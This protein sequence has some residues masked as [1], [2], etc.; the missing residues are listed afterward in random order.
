MQA[1]FI[2]EELVTRIRQ[3]TDIVEVVSRYV[4]L[5]KAGKNLSGLCPFHAEKSPSFLVNPAKQV[6]HCFGC[7]AGGNV[8][9]FL[10]RLEGQ[11]FPQV[12]RSLAER[13]GIA[14]PERP[15]DAA[16]TQEQRER[17]GLLE[18]QRQAA[19]YFA[20]Q[21]HTSPAAAPARQ[22]LQE[23]GINAATIAAFRL[24]FAPAAWDGL[25]TE[26]RRKGWSEALIDRGGLAIPRSG[27]A[28]GRSGYYDRFRNRVMFPICDVQDRI[29]GF[30]GRVLD[31]STPK[32]LNS[33]ETPLFSKGRNLYAL[34]RARSGAG[35]RNYIVVV[36]G[37]FD[38]IMAHQVGIPVVVATLGTALTPNHLQIMQRFSGTVK[39]IFDPDPA[40]IRAALRAVDMI[41]PSGMSAEVV[42]LP[43]G[44]DP[45]TF[46]RKQGPQAFEEQ[47]AR[48]TNLLDFA[49]EQHLL[50]P[51]A[52]TLAG[53]LKIAQ[54]LIGAIQRIAHPLAR[55]YQIKRLAEGIGFKEDDLLRELDRRPRPEARPAAGPAP[56]LRAPLPREE[57][58]LAHLVIH[59]LVPLAQILEQVEI[60][61][62]TD[63]R[64]QLVVQALA[65]CV[66]TRGTLDLESLADPE[67]FGSETASLIS[68]LSVQEAEYDDAHQTAMDCLRTMKLKRWKQSM[69]ELELRIRS[70]EQ[71]D[72][73]GLVKDLQLQLMGLKKQALSLAN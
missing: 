12:V 2:P 69:T 34:D 17:E 25:L 67:A 32:Y 24:G 18:L 45:D 42:L 68:A 43:Q 53:R 20:Q 31:D 33:P 4:T 71:S 11:A 49:L 23:R 59:G 27:T 1:S 16:E 61:D 58:F 30:G 21:L 5:K 10:M 28:A 9:T 73:T 65:D 26:L 19:D 8:F 6:F 66:R 44:D 35:K 48:A 64:L 56:Q 52:K 63:P 36:E 47:L 72:N 62:F 41:L 57:H 37:Y 55:S 7:Q 54:E 29:I 51:G 22:Y 15:M 50:Q 40:G 13:L 38:A 3:D 39:L 60:T 46:I 14:L 70:A